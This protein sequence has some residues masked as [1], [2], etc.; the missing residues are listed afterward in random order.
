VSTAAS[1]RRS[2]RAQAAVIRC[3]YAPRY[4]GDNLS[5]ASRPRLNIFRTSGGRPVDPKSQEELFLDSLRH[6]EDVVLYCCSRSLDKQ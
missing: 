2:A 4:F 6:E 3:N 1:Q 5:V